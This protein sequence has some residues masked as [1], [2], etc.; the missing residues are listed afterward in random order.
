ML[1]ADEVQ[2]LRARVVLFDDAIADV[3]PIEAR[4]ENARVIQREAVNDLIARD[5]IRGGRQRDS[6]HVRKALVQHRQLNVFRPEI[7]PP[8]RH[9]M[10]FVDGEQADARALQ[11][12]LET[13]RHQAL[14]RDVEQVDLTVAQRALGRH[15]LGA[16]QRRIQIRGAH[17]HFGERGHL[18]LHQ[19]DQRRHDDARAET[20]FAAHQRRNLIAQRLAAARRHQHEAIAAAGDVLDNFALLSSERGVTEDFV[21]DFERT[22]HEFERSSVMPVTR[23]L[24]THSCCARALRNVSRFGLRV[25]KEAQKESA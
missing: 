17:A 12:F 13:G 18:I 22:G 20:A 5:G 25:R 7:V 11:Q 15:R 4:H 10:R 19:R 14:R 23:I 24:P 8:L 1:G 21:E 16:R 2:Q 3:R 9:A 6:R